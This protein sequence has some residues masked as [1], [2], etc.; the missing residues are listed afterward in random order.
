MSIIVSYSAKL[1]TPLYRLASGIR[2][3]EMKWSNP[4]RLD[5]YGVRLVGWPEGIPAQNPS[6]LKAGQ[7][8]AL[9][10]ALQSG[11]MRFERSDDPTRLRP[12]AQVSDPNEEDA[13]EDFSWA[14]DAD[15]GL[16]SPPRP[17]HATVPPSD[18][19]P[20]KQ[21][22]FVDSR[23]RL[24]VASTSESAA[25]KNPWGM[26]PVRASEVDP[27]LAKEN[28]RPDGYNGHAV[29]RTLQDQSE[30]VSERPRKRPRNEEPGGSGIT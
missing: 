22:V 3:A 4:E 19:P 9:L 6:S 23:P 28:P 18:P 2:N 30:S 27:V 13:A 16:N 26:G 29:N 25:E 12:P 14:Y 15:A 20:A 17:E 5:V 24:P 1:T 10:E 7:N 8:K 11:S 21:Y